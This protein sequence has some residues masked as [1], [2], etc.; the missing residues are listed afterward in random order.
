MVNIA[1]RN[2][3]IISVFLISLIARSYLDGL[4]LAAIE[5]FEGERHIAVDGNHRFSRC[6]GALC[7]LERD[8][9]FGAER[10]ALYAV[11]FGEIEVPSD[12]VRRIIGADADDKL[13]K[14]GNRSQAG[15]ADKVLTSHKALVH[16]FG[17]IVF[18]ESAGVFKHLKHLM[19]VI[20]WDSII[21]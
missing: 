2:V 5:H 20:S 12:G 16:R 18:P 9:P 13:Y 19:I 4:A 10:I 15:P 14:F 11:G 1:V 21:K 6:V 3:F 7:S 8:A 17:R